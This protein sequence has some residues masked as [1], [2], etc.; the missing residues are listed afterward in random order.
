MLIYPYECKESRRRVDCIGSN[1]RRGLDFRSVDPHFKA[2]TCRSAS[3]IFDL[4][5][6]GMIHSLGESRMRGNR[7][8]LG[9][10]IV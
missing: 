9:Y 5:D 2:F 4:S 6:I 8:D 7:Q 1:T 10:N 3:R